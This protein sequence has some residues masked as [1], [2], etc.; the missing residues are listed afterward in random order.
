M[1][2]F[3]KVI[4]IALLVLIVIKSQNKVYAK[5]VSTYSEVKSGIIGIEVRSI[6]EE[7]AKE[8]VPIHTV[9]IIEREDKWYYYFLDNKVLF[10]S[11]LSG[12]ILILIIV[13]IFNIKRNRRGTRR[14]YKKPK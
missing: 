5:E 3:F 8:Y 13:I 14:W 1:R 9:K 11:C 7:E 4:F 10:I 12:V 6:T 2:K